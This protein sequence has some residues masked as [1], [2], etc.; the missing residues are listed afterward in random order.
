MEGASAEVYLSRERSSVD[1]GAHG[2]SYRMPVDLDAY[3]GMDLRILVDA[4]IVEVFA[5]DGMALTARVYPVSKRSI[6]LLVGADDAS[7]GAT[8]RWWPLHG[9]MVPVAQES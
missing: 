9:G 4:S 5:G 8:V 2:G 3:G 6:G 7:G 1:P